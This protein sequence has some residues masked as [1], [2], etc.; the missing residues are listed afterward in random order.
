MKVTNVKA[1]GWILMSIDVLKHF[2]LDDLNLSDQ[3]LVN[4]Y[5]EPYTEFPYMNEPFHPTVPKALRLCISRNLAHE[6]V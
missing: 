5:R 3:D 1:P 2:T 6:R 4:K